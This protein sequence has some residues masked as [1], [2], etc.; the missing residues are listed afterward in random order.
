M[1]SKK[2]EDLVSKHFDFLREK[3]GFTV[4]SSG[5]NFT[6]EDLSIGVQHAHG[7]LNILFTI[8]GR[9]F[10][11]FYFPDVLTKVTGEPFSY[12]EHFF[13]VVITMGDVNSRLAYDAKMMQNHCQEVLDVPSKLLEL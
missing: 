8:K 5:L 1:Q 6:K 4:D 3:Y 2:I 13:S 12:P 11:L 7:A 10:R 9:Q